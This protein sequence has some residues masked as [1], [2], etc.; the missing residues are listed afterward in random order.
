M[1]PD[2][3][4]PE[5]WVALV[6]PTHGIPYYFDTVSQRA[7]WDLPAAVAGVAASLLLPSRAVQAA[8]KY[9]K[10]FESCLS[11]CLYEKTKITKGIAQV[12]VISRSEAYAQCKPKCAT[13][14]EQLLIGK[15]K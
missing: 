14:K 7:Q 12:E 13:S 5:G 4:L 6:D 15:P 9:D 8:S 2:G 10:D 3:A 1:L 11:K